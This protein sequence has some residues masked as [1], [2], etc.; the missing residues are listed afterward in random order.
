[1]DVLNECSNP[2][3]GNFAVDA[4]TFN[5]VSSKCLLIIL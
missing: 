1:M 2:M 3:F 4:F 5:N